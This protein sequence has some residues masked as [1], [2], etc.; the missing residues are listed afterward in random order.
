MFFAY[1]NILF[2][3]FIAPAAKEILMDYV[4]ENPKWGLLDMY[5][6]MNEDIIELDVNACRP[7]S[8]SR[9]NDKISKL[10]YMYKEHTALLLKLLRTKCPVSKLNRVNLKPGGRFDHVDHVDLANFFIKTT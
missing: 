10:H 8:D 7:L 2:S 1:V 3:I 9:D 6:L 5:V 4:L